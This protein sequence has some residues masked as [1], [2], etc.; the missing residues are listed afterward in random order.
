MY[1]QIC[2]QAAV[3][4]PGNPEGQIQPLKI[5]DEWPIIASSNIFILAK[6]ARDHSFIHSTDICGSTIMCLV[7]GK[8]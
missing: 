7:L 3:L 5:I 6:E 1:R 2:I 8:I 4:I